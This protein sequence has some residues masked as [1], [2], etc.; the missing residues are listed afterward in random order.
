MTEIEVKPYESIN[1]QSFPEEVKLVLLKEN[2]KTD[3]KEVSFFSCS[4]FLH[5]KTSNDKHLDSF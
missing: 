3:F 4:R 1:D 2:F 5:V